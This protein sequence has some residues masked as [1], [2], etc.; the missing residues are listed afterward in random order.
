MPGLNAAPRQ[1]GL[2]KI[3]EIDRDEKV[4]LIGNRRR[5]NMPIRWIRQ[6]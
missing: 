5:K 4:H 1:C 2:R 6:H 3:L